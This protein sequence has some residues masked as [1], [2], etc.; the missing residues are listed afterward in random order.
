MR[1]DPR[2]PCVVCTS[3]VGVGRGPY[4]VYV[5]SKAEK[6]EPFRRFEALTKRLLSVPKKDV[7]K[8]EA[9]R[10]KRKRRRAS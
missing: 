7:D 4:N 6:P 3:I 5:A 1:L 2:P 10:P 9:E 8:K